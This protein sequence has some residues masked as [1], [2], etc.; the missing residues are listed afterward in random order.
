VEQ[1]VKT[2]RPSVWLTEDFP[3]SV[4]EFLPLLDILASRVRTV[5]RLRE[6]LTNKFP[7]G[8]FH[9]KVT[10]LFLLLLLNQGHKITCRPNTLQSCR[11]DPP[12]IYS[13]L[14]SGDVR[15]LVLP[16]WV[17]DSSRQFLC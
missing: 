3:L 4:D 16:R 10:T 5:H 15:I 7:S 13:I 8:T 6:L 2:L 9:V 14:V 17:G 1:T 12:C 11:D